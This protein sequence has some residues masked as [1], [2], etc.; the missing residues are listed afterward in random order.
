MSPFYYYPPCEIRA[1]PAFVNQFIV[2]SMQYPS[3]SLEEVRRKY[4][5]SL[6]NEKMINTQLREKIENFQKYQ[7]KIM[8]VKEVAMEDAREMILDYLKSNRNVY[9]SKIASDLSLSI[10]TVLEIISSLNK[11]GRIEIE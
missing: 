9:T 3:E 2:P 8:V 1:T 4:E 6:I 10:E 5:I 11:A 7:P